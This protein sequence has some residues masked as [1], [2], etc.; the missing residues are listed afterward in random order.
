MSCH[1]PHMIRSS[2]H[3]T[4]HILVRVGFNRSTVCTNTVCYKLCYKIILFTVWMPLTITVST[5]LLLSVSDQEHGPDGP[6]I[7]L[8][9]DSIWIRSLIQQ[10]V[11]MVHIKEAPKSC[12]SLP[13]EHWRCTARS[14]HLSQT[15]FPWLYAAAWASSCN[16]TTD[17]QV[18]LF[19]SKLLMSQ[20]TQSYN[21]GRFISYNYLKMWRDII[22]Y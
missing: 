22:V 12:S 17:E 15:W 8:Q 2:L 6:E 16:I 9:Q 21:S 20:S 3:C 19:L 11:G 18:L 5:Q 10:C 13:G 4:A 1:E 14:S 7:L